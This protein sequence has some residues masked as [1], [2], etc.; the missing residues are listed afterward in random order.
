MVEVSHTSGT[1]L[2]THARISA[3]LRSHFDIRNSVLLVTVRSLFFRCGGGG[4]AL[5]RIV[6][7]ASGFVFCLSLSVN[8]PIS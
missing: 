4:G 6:T 3:S 1:K 2:I 7:V 5:F 8:R